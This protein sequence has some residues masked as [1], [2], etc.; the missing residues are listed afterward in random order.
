MRELEELFAGHGCLDFQWI[1]PRQ[2]LV[3]QWVRLKCQ[4]GCQEYGRNASCPPNVPAVAECGRF[5]A[6]Y[7]KAAVFHF[8]KAVER[9]ED[10]HAWTRQLNRALLELERAVFLAGYQR[11]FMLF[12]D[13][14]GLCKQC[15]GTRAECK[16]PRSAR[17]TAEAMAVDVFSTVRQVGHPIEVLPDCRQAMNRYAFLMIE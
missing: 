15:A 13:S 16:D 5:F 8:Q 14:C 2:I 11:A 7:G 9:P 17:P 10:R 1:D 12:M 3:A 4:F 6:E